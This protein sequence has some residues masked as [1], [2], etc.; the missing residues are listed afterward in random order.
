MK[1]YSLITKNNKQISE[2]IIVANSMS[3]AT[4]VGVVAGIVTFNQYLTVAPS[5]IKIPI[6]NLGILCIFGSVYMI[7][8]QNQKTKELI[9]SRGRL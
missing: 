2:S 1:K 3:F 5:I 9:H 7:K 8:K 4:G 6:V